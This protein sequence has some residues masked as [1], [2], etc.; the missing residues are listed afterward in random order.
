MVC[1]T[2]WTKIESYISGLIDTSSD[3]QREIEKIKDRRTA[4]QSFL[5]IAEIRRSQDANPEQ[6]RK[7]ENWV[8]MMRRYA[9]EKVPYT[10]SAWV[11]EPITAFNESEKE[12]YLRMARSATS[13]EQVK[14]IAKEVGENPYITS[15]TKK[16]TIEAI[17]QLP[18]RVVKEAIP[19]KPKP[20]YIVR[21]IK[22]F[23]EQ[24]LTI[25]DEELKR[26][27]MRTAKSFKKFFYLTEEEAKMLADRK[28]ALKGGKRR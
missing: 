1:T 3:M 23:R 8:I 12:R 17:S 18:R 20:E 22:I 4:V 26:L 24:A 9:R 13:I 11:V 15:E 14:N 7:E 28:R 25:S 6:R 27:P 16:E 5:N 2:D 10:K 19:V 21:R